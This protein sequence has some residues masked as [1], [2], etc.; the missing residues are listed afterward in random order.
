M[1]ESEFE[2]GLFGQSNE[3]DNS[4]GSSNSYQEGWI[5]SYID[6]LTLLLTLF[7]ILLAMS[8]F[9]ADTSS[10]NQLSINLDHTEKQQKQIQS[11]NINFVPEPENQHKKEISNNK[12]SSSSVNTINKLPTVTAKLENEVPIIADALISTQDNDPQLETPTH[13]DIDNYLSINTAK[14]FSNEI[15]AAKILPVQTSYNK[16]NA[17]SLLQEK[18]TSN[19]T[20]K[21]K[22]TQNKT[23][24]SQERLALIQ[25]IENSQLIDK[26]D[27]NENLGQVNL[28]IKDHV[29]FSPGSEKLKPEG[30]NLL[31]DLAI[32][33]GNSRF[34]LSVEGHTDNAPIN[35]QS[36]H[37]NWELSTARAT[38]VTHHLIESNV[39]AH[40]LRAI[41]YADTRPRADNA[42]QQG[43]ESNRR[44]SITLHMPDSH[45]Q[46][47]PP[48]A[49]LPDN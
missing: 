23:S 39:E 44:V 42:T 38:M 49:M 19:V 34:N 15:D 9:K 4:D 20:A 47:K 2:F 1:N 29:L 24:L 37:S 5:I 36:F 3:D 10:L 14:M 32:M 8:H 12:N 6:I 11:S 7:V 46:S 45:K 25:Q 13:S 41:G 48:V 40:R 30:L 43:R 35:N 33:L 16:E 18:T 22:K 26:I 28:V 27:I 17:I 21:G 31:E